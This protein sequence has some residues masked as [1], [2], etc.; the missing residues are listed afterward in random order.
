MPIC[1]M[2]WLNNMPLYVLSPLILQKIIWIPT[3]IIMKFFGRIQISG[4]ENLKDIKTNVIFAPNHSGEMDPILIP[5]SLGFFSRFSP[6]FYTSREQEFYVNCGWRKHFYGGILFE[7]W[8]A[9]SVFPGQG[10]YAKGLVNHL[11]IVGIGGNLC[12]FPEGGTSKDGN[13]RPAKGGIAYLAEKTGRPIVPVSMYGV[14]QISAREFFGRKRNIAIHFGKP[15]YAKDLL[16]NTAGG[17]DYKAASQKVMDLVGEGLRI[18]V[19]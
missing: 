9:Y 17:N 18:S 1:G 7:M 16:V 10:D 8:G 19:L 15:V 13:L 12:M 6:I 5:A 3:R 14:V 11:R 2:I 4:L